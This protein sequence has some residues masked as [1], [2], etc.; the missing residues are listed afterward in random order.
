SDIDS[1]GQLVLITTEGNITINEG[2]QD[3]NGVAG[4]NNILL[5]ASGI[6]DITINADINSKEGNISI[7]AGQDIIQNADIST[8]L[9]SKTI[10]LFANRHITMSSD[11]S[12]ITTD[13]NIQLDSNTG[14]IT[15][16]FLDAG[17]GDA[18]IISKAGDIIDL[19][20]AEDNEVDIQSSGLILSADSGIGSGNNHIEISVNTLTAKAGSDGIFITETNAITID[21]QTININRVDATAKDSATHNASQTDL[22]TVLNGNIVLVAG[23]T[24]EI[25][26]G[27]DSNN[28]A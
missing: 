9:I 27:G 13:G 2:D 22:T 18:R 19:G 25:N 12:T 23:G 24:I 14:N 17:I 21:S 11:T 16:E 8:D 1:D 7:N 5:Q 20:I 15:L 10:D 26:E 28:K 3:D 4:M 6:S